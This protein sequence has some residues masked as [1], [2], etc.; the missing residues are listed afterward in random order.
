VR[1]AGIAVPIL[2]LLLGAAD[3][4]SAQF[5]ARLGSP[6]AGSW[7]AAGGVTWSG[8]IDGPDSTAEL[9][10]NGQSS[11]GF[12]LFT[13]ES[14][15][16]NGAGLWTTLGFYLSRSI[17]IEGGLRYSKPQLTYELSGDAEDAADTT[18]S[19][20]LSRYVIT[21]SVVVHLGQWS[22]GRVVPFVAGGAGYIR[23][24]HE[25]AELVETGTEYHAVAGVKY[26]FGTARRR[27]GVRGQAGLSITDGGFDFRDS[28]RTLPI[29]SA[30]LVYLF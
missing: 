28:S 5:P 8:S 1:R 7:E 22:S 14:R 6:R 29:A 17:V 23:D 3:V 4:A 19:E 25:G 26:W 20:T 27:F 30:S 24:L 13:S 9:T 2:I 21:G 12:D 16:R 15:L 18:A 11:G 10:E